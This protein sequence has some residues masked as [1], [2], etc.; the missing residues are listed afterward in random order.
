[1]SMTVVVTRDVADRFRGFLASCML[2]IGPG[3]YTAPRM[4][5]AVRDR[6]WEVLTEW[7]RELGGGSILMTWP[8]NRLTGGQAV[9]T[10]GS[11]P[12]DLV[13][14]DGIVLSVRDSPGSQDVH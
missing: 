10:L 8:D 13:D 12:I 11:P 9:R 5:A 14:V 2:E 3:V 1:M 4:S 7:F 6:V